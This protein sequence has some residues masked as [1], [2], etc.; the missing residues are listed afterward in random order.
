M[1]TVI[2]AGGLGTRLAE[3]TEIKPKPM[4]EIGGRPI[5]WHIM[6]IYSH[7]GF[8]EFYIALGYKGEVIKRFFFDYH[9]LSGDVSM[10]FASGQVDVKNRDCEDW[11][12]HLID[13]GLNS[14]TG[15]R[16]RRLEK[17]LGNETFMVTYGD[18]VSNVDV[19]ELVR[20]HRSH[21]KLATVTA[22]HPPARWGELLIKEDL[23]TEFSEK[24]Q[25]HEGWINGGFLVFEPKVF[26]YLA[27]DE[28][29]LE[30]EVLE[31]LAGEKQLAAYRHGDFWQC[32]DTLRDKRQ[33]E[34]AWEAGSPPWKVW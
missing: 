25:A 14:M 12:V 2:L 6:K 8:R 28:S 20:F 26:D 1:K 30:L 19:A 9:S 13:T 33:L 18:G 21:G 4:V 11:T 24:P 7:Y 23:T 15:G 31:R 10:N 3:E 5:L 22:V 16:I 17:F 34:S 29:I 32:M 27:G